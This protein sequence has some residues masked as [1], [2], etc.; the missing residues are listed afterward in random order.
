MTVALSNA[1]VHL[2]E[3]P[4]RRNLDS[5]GVRHIATFTVTFGT[6]IEGKGPLLDQTESNV[7]V[8]PLSFGIRCT[9]RE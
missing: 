4:A 5:T 7:L 6:N 3:R 9:M 1:L 8:F 2:N